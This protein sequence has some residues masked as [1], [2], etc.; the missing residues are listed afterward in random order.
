MEW[1]RER[2]ESS[3]EVGSLPHSLSSKKLFK[4]LSDKAKSSS[5]DLLTGQGLSW[6]TKACGVRLRAY[7][8]LGT[9]SPELVSQLNERWNFIINILLIALTKKIDQGKICSRVESM[10]C[11]LYDVRSVVSCKNEEE[12]RG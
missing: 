8:K 11:H 2:E 1:E 6:Q 12:E 7:N 9:L 10:Y 5:N 4:Y 3:L